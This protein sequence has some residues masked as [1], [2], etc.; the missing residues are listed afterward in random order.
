MIHRS[1]LRDLTLMLASMITIIGTTAI[2]PSLPKMD[3]FFRGVPNGHYL[4]LISLTLPA[5]SAGL[6]GPLM[7]FVIDRWGRKRVFVLALVLYGLSGISGFFLSSLPLI[8]A[9]RFVLGISVAALTTSATALIGDYTERSKLAAAMGR[10]SLFMSFGNVVFV[11][12]S[13]VLA[14]FNWRFPF[15][16]YAISFLILPGAVWLLSDKR[17]PIGPKV[18]SEKSRAGI[19]A[20]RTALVCLIGFANMVAYFMV[21]VYLPFYMRSFSASTMKVGVLLSL[22][23]L[24]WALSSSQY[25]R[26]RKNL[27]F[28]RIAFLGLTLNAAAY[29]LLAYAST[30]AV[31]IT[32]LILLGIGLGTMLPNLNAW[33]LSFIPEALKG[34][35]IGLLFFFIFMGQFF[36]PVIT[37][38]LTAMAGISRSYFFASLLLVSIGLTCGLYEYWQRRVS[39]REIHHS[40]EEKN[41]TI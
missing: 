34:R 16:I 1:T 36:S 10:Q 7:G 40:P 27:A 3:D 39:A 29:M 19:P 17:A 18:S 28:E 26:L 20:G 13:G 15:L 30:Y 38:P 5:L 33:L 22:V 23:G 6:F 14:G 12:L 37:H 24:S 4:V 8:L 2:S 32:A 11:S 9:S 41:Q 31:V 21:P 25:R 35:A